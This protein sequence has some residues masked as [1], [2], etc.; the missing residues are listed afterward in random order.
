MERSLSEIRTM[1]KPIGERRKR[2]EK[3]NNNNITT[4]YVFIG[5]ILNLLEE[6]AVWSLSKQVS[7]H[8]MYVHCL[9]MV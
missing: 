6:R 5:L 3:S 2:R 9:Q 4:N 7:K 8:P 1:Q